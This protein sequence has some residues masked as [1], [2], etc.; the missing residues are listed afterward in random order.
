[1][2]ALKAILFRGGDISAAGQH[3]AFLAVFTVV[4]L[5]LSTVTMKRTL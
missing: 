2:A 3:V 1:V 5:F 4:M